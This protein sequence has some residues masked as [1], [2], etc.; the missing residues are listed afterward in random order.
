M[1]LCKIHVSAHAVAPFP[2]IRVLQLCLTPIIT[3]IGSLNGKQRY[4]CS[5]HNVCGAEKKRVEKYFVVKKL[6][7]EYFDACCT[8]I[9]DNSGVVV[10]AGI[11]YLD[12]TLKLRIRFGI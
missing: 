3:T 8:I 1:A 7:W 11:E 2:H 10:A 12:C 6:G 5:K 4:S 9:A